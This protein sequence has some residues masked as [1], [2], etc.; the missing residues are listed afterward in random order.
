MPL[1]TPS[2]AALALAR[3]I[4][5]Y[6]NMWD[7]VAAAIGVAGDPSRLSDE[8]IHVAHDEQLKMM[9]IAAFSVVWHQE[10]RLRRGEEP[11]APRHDLRNEGSDWNYDSSASC[12]QM[13][14]ILTQE[15]TL[16][17]LAHI[18][19]LDVDGR[20]WDRGSYLFVES[21]D[22]LQARTVHA[23]VL[24]VDPFARLVQLTKQQDSDSLPAAPALS[25]IA[26]HPQSPTTQARSGGVQ[27]PSTIWINRRQ[28]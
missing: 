21:A 3:L 15:S 1:L 4:D 28:G 8:Q 10:E 12:L 16:R 11:G 2:P 27:Q 20:T 17:M 7:A 22:D 14:D 18:G 19:D 13:T 6:A 25:L 23:F 26:P 5:T 24:T 9:D